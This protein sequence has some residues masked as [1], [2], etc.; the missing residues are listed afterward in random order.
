LSD[1][2]SVLLGNTDGTFRIPAQLE[3]GREPYSVVVADFNQDGHLDLLASSLV[4]SDL[5][6]YLGRGDGTFETRRILST[7]TGPGPIVVG[8]FNGDGRA[9]AA[10]A[11]LA[12]DLVS[13]FLGNG[14]GTFA[15]QM[16]FDVGDNPQALALGDL[17]GDGKQD[18][19]TGNLLSDDLS[20]LLGVGDGTFAPQI[21]VPA[22]NQPGSIALG[23]LDGD[24]TL[25]C[26][27]TINSSMASILRGRGDGTFSPLGQVL[28]ERGSGGQ[29]T[30]V[31]G[32]AKLDLL[33]VNL[34]SLWVLPGH[35]DGTFEAPIKVNVGANP[36]SLDVVDLNHDGRPDLAVSSLSGGVATFFGNGGGTFGPPAPLEAGL[37]PAAVAVGDLDVDGRP[38]LVVANRD[39]DSLSV[40]R[41]TGNGTFT[42]P[43]H[44]ATGLAPTSL[45][46]DDFN[47]DG[48]P[49]V[50]VTNGDTRDVSVLLGTGG[51][52]LTSQPRIPLSDFPVAIV[53]ADFNADAHEDLAI[54]TEDYGV[55]VLLGR[56]DGSFAPQVRYLIEGYNVSLSTGDVNRDGKTD[57]LAL[58]R[59]TP[60]GGCPSGGQ[61]LILPGLGDGT[62]G[63]PTQF[64]TGAFSHSFTVSDLN[65]DGLPDVV[66]SVE[67]DFGPGPTRPG[68]SMLLGDGA[69][70]FQPAALFP[71][72]FSAGSVATG[73]FDGDGVRDV[74]IAGSDSIVS[75][76]PGNG[77]G[78]FR[79][80]L[81]FVAGPSSSAVAVGDFNADR[82]NDL[83]V[84][85][86]RKGVFVMLNEGPFPDSDRDGIP[87]DRDP[88]TDT[89][90]DEWGD[91]GFPFNTCA[92]DNCPSVS[93]PDQ[94][95]ADQDGVGDA[96]D[97]CPSDTL[98]DP[99]ADGLCGL[100]DNCPTIANA[101]QGDRDGDGVGDACDNCLTFNNPG[102]QDSNR[103]GY[104]DACQPRAVIR[105]IGQDGGDTLEVT[106]TIGDPLGK[107]LSGAIQFL[108]LNQTVALRA[109][110]FET[111]DCTADVYPST[112]QGEGVAYVADPSGLSLL[113]D[114]A[115]VAGCKGGVQN[116]EVA[117]GSC[118]S[119]TSGFD[120]GV[121]L[122]QA[123]P[124]TFVCVHRV[125]DPGPGVDLE[126]DHLD[127]Q[128]LMAKAAPT[129]AFSVP[130]NGM[131][132]DHTSI[133]RLAAETYYALRLTVTNGQESA[134]GEETF[135]HRD[136]SV[137]VITSANVAPV[138]RISAPSTVECTS[139]SGAVV[140]LDASASTD[141]D[142]SPGTHDD[143]LLF[144]WFEDLGLP[145]QKTLGSGEVLNAVLS[146]GSHGIGLR[147]TDSL[148]ATSTAE[149]LI[150]VHDTTPPALSCPSPS[151]AECGGPDGASVTLAATAIDVCGG[152]TI[153]NSRGGGA[154]ASGIYPLGTTS[155]TFTATDVS[156]TSASCTSAVTV[157]DTTPP[158][159][160]LEVDPAQLWPPNHRMV[161]VK[162]AWQIADRCDPSATIRLISANSSES[163][164]AT[165]S[166]DGNTTEDIQGAS[167][168]TTDSS[169]LLRAERSGSGPG[170]VYT[171]TYSAR[172]ASGNATSA[173]AMVTVPQ[174]EGTGPEPVMVNVEGEG[175]PGMAHLYWNAVSGAEMYDVIQG[176][177]SQISVVDREIWL[178][179]VHV[180]ASGQTGASYSEGPSGT[181]PSVGRAFFYLV[182]YRAGQSASGWGTESSPWPAE[183]SSCDVGCPGE[184]MAPS[185]ASRTTRRK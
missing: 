126:I 31:T 52:E 108:T 26:V 161:P 179:P 66:V 42:P 149:D 16:Q 51:G 131:L 160:S 148:G 23:D 4:S 1:S 93:N 133:S 150:S 140:P 167:I 178:G 135:L 180:T 17:N 155:L 181:I 41:G 39:S 168:D 152:V 77:D 48:Q 165:G 27:V 67:A 172:D 117:K 156:G 22:G 132:P 98:N 79:D 97:S 37:S 169:V 45:V 138:A 20:I 111:L 129:L 81:R 9:D 176:D 83:V 89:D 50:A 143:I 99:D 95:D 74:V 18:L 10:V 116:Y 130:F 55:S 58:K 43:R 96:C 112:G 34:D 101:D 38:D 146:L 122:S 103:D 124:A 159:V 144:Q 86:T 36:S 73:D 182:Q 44:F 46:I 175:T 162:V 69:G 141:Q 28:T 107:P 102:Q 35:G 59:C 32:D 128:A 171:L 145:T 68:F 127:L 30:D 15:P 174:D 185:V 57:L 183:P 118:S 142:S 2:V 104:G 166:G 19:M 33:V 11:N 114:L 76:I 29:L 88:C 134:V 170:R 54:L 84:T 49:D 105:E 163:D 56:G 40:F 60:G 14:D 91:P 87:D 6:L 82:R 184:T 94:A 75:I 8:D 157:S 3:S 90:G 173:L 72:R 92:S 139:P 5:S 153:T 24:G 71:T 78:T 121:D 177:L 80:P 70:G 7:A 115:A 136:E 13:V 125:G 85:S 164:D 151:T 64:S 123:G 154:D 61:L 53:A 113:L 25:D 147:V 110:T 109:R 106:A 100:Q 62:F 119:P 12:A 63:S 65:E 120:F 47:E 21:R 158:T 137:M